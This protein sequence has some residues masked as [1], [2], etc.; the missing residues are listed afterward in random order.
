[1]IQRKFEGVAQTR[2]KDILPQK[3]CVI[4]RI[5]QYSEQDRL[6]LIWE[7]RQPQITSRPGFQGEMD[8]WMFYIGLETAQILR[9][10]SSKIYEVPII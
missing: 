6:D 8:K 4:S 2:V 1:V 3:E 10:S 7:M 5:I 9:T